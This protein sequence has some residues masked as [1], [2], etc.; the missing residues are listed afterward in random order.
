MFSVSNGAPQLGKTMSK[1]MFQLLKIKKPY[2][3]I[4]LDPD[5]YINAINIFQ[6]LSAI[7]GMDAD[8]IKIVKLKGKNDL[9][10]IRRNDG[11][12]KVRQLL[13]T[14]TTLTTDDYLNQR[15]Y[16]N[17]YEWKAKKY[18]RADRENKNW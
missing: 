9:D 15:K 5:A 16:R 14:A 8:K 10:E 6:T 7:Y 2:I 12:E 18:S 11:D 4:V 13:R 3:V 1:R 17:K